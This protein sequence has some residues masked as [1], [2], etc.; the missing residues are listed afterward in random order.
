MDGIG[1]L[2]LMK[3]IQDTAKKIAKTKNHK[4]EK[5]QENS[6]KIHCDKLSTR[7]K[8]LRYKAQLN[9]A[10]HRMVELQVQMA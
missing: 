1:Q 4:Y 5:N 2:P 6:D 9:I 10:R 3:T 8:T 7:K